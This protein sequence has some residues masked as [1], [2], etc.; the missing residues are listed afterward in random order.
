MIRPKIA[1]VNN[2]HPFSGMGKYAFNLFENYRKQNKNVKMFYLETKTNKIGNKKGVMKIRKDL[3]FIQLNKTVLTYYWF[4]KKIPAG[5]NLYHAT[6]QF[7]AKLA[8]YRR[9]CIITHMDMRP[10]ILPTDISMRLTGL[11]LKQLLGYYKYADKIIALDEIVKD[12][13]I[14]RKIV[15]EEKVNVIYPGFNP[16]VYKP[17]KKTVARRRLGL[18]MD[19]KIVINV[20]SEEP[21]KNIPL[22]LEVSKRL[23]EEIKNLMLI[24]IG[25][26]KHSGSY[27]KIS[28]KLK[29]EVNLREYS[30]VPEE[31]MCYFY[32]AADVCI[33]PVSYS[34][35]FMFPPLEAMACGTPSIVSSVLAKA[36]GDG[37]LV[38]KELKVKLWKD[39]V[40]AVLTDKKLAKKLS[41]KGLKCAKKFT[42]EKSLK[43][44]W[45]IYESVLSE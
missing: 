23:Q 37:S 16:E 25:G 24:R 22:V 30:S 26:S 43:A 27:W 36:F 19:K 29:K 18:S 12:Q 21:I 11:A 3:H 39:A 44:T 20:G 1:L 40:Y 14:E 42:L 8:K 33:T 45:R 17:V 5:F 15:P 13:L 6:N 38:V 4:P 31:E 41:R 2:A 35:G 9:P 34:E 10:I 32:S 7:L 28:Q